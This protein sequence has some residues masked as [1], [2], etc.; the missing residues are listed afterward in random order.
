MKKNDTIFVTITGVSSEGNGIG[1]HDGMAVFIP[2]TACGD[3]VEALVVKVCKSYAHGKLV[4]VLKPSPDRV[5]SDCPVFLSAADVSI[6]IS[7]MR[8]N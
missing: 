3:E 7:P 2:G 4:R 8:R 1:R 6:A 5:E